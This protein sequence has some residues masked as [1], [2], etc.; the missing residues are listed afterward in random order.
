MMMSLFNPTGAAGFASLAT[1]GAISILMTFLLSIL[2][3]PSLLPPGARPEGAARALFNYLMQVVGIILMVASGFPAVVS[4]LTGASFVPQS[5]LFLLIIFATGGLTFLWYEQHISKIDPASRAVPALI[6]HSLFKFLGFFTTFTAALTILS[7]LLFVP[8]AA[9]S[10]QWWPSPLLL[11]AFGIF[12]LW[13][14]ASP[15]PSRPFRTEAMNGAQRP[16]SK[17]LPKKRK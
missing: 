6:F 4:V 13:C 5:Y 1:V 3:I 7:T 12:L 16:A 10:G 2:L 11:L 15:S 8:H 9:L 14:T 17:P